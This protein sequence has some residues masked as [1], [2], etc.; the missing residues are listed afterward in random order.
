MITAASLTHP[1]ACMIEAFI[2]M[3]HVVF[4]ISQNFFSQ[5]NKFPLHAKSQQKLLPSVA[6]EENIFLAS[7]GEKIALMFS[8]GILDL[9]YTVTCDLL[10]TNSVETMATFRVN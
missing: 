9:V 6:L 10:I 7:I 8:S 1:K 2:M 4:N 3:H 5:K